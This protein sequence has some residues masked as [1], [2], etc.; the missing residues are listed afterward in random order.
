MKKCAIVDYGLCNLLSVSNALR[1]LGV[2]PKIISSSDG[3]KGAD[4]AI[5][6]GVGAFEDG[7]SGLKKS[8]LIEPIFDFIR[9]GKPFLGI[10]LGM[11]LFMDKSYEF[12]VHEGLGRIPGEVLPFEMQ[13]KNDEYALKVPHIGWSSLCQ[14]G[15]QWAGTVLTGIPYQSEMYFVHSFFF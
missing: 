14:E 9:S 5:L 2:E 8:G 6:P 4:C 11:E 13:M 7:I 3:F 10:C 12:G 15:A 1:F